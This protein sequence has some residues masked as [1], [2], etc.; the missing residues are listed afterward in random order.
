MSRSRSNEPTPCHRTQH[1]SAAMQ[2]CEGGRR[3]GVAARGEGSDSTMPSK[4]D[5]NIPAH[6]CFL[7]S[8]DEDSDW[9]PYPPSP[10]LS[11]KTV[12]IEPR[13]RYS[14]RTSTLHQYGSAKRR[15]G[16]KPSLKEELL[17]RTSMDAAMGHTEPRAS[18]QT[19][20][21]RSKTTRL[22]YTAEE[23]IEIPQPRRRRGSTLL[24]PSSPIIG[25]A[26]LHTDAPPTQTDTPSL[27]PQ[28]YPCFENRPKTLL[29]KGSSLLHPSPPLSDA[30]SEASM[31]IAQLKT[32]LSFPPRKQW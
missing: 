2:I 5:S 18:T 12:V 21:S 28:P 4:R 19:G 9:D 30:E 26:I 31:R 3:G 8:E 23:G 22:D 29:R 16:W 13:S 1:D 6:Q 25:S 15:P 11:P 10:P 32:V 17:R 20:R 24:H 14:Q 27:P 7:L